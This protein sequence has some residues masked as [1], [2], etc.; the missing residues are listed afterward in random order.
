MLNVDHKNENGYRIT[1]VVHRSSLDVIATGST[2]VMSVLN[3]DS[4]ICPLCE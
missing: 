1:R 3:L 4:G 2:G